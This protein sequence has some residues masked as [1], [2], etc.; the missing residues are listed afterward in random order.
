MLRSLID[1]FRLVAQGSISISS[2]QVDFL[3]DRPISIDRGIFPVFCPNSSC[4]I[5]VEMVP[6]VSSRCLAGLAGSAVST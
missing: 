1:T 4:S 5:G 6:R 3:C 2:Y